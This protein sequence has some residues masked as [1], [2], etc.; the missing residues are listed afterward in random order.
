MGSAGPV[1]SAVLVDEEEVVVDLMVDDPVET[2]TQYE[3]P[4]QKLVSQSDDTA[5]FQARN[6]ADVIPNAAS[7]DAPEHISS[8]LIFL[9]TAKGPKHESFSTTSYQRLQVAIVPVCV[10][11]SGVVWAVTLRII[12]FGWMASML[13]LTIKPKKKMAT[14]KEKECILSNIVITTSLRKFGAS[15]STTR[16]RRS[17]RQ[18]RRASNAGLT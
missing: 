15:L 5:G 11:S 13:P 12:R 9:V 8:A 17:Q 14:S 4:T 10:G 7:T 6:S 2:P 3:S 18:T 1:V 16:A